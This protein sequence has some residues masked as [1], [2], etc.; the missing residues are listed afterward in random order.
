MCIRDRCL[1]VHLARIEMAI[2]FEE[3]LPRI[4]SL[5]LAGTPKRTVTNFVGG[6]RSLPVRVRLRRE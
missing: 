2:L 1:G 4:E 3:L 5:E 6:P